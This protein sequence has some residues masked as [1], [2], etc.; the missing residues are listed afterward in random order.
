MTG[1]L[2]TQMTEKQWQEGRERIRELQG[3]HFREKGDEME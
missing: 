3:R 1:Q 2:W